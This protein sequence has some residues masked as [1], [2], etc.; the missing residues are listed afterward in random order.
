MPVVRERIDRSERLL[1]AGKRDKEATQSWQLVREELG[2]E[3][4]RYRLATATFLQGNAGE[5]NMAAIEAARNLLKQLKDVYIRQYNNAEQA[6]ERAHAAQVKRFGSDESLE[7]VRR[8]GS[9]ESL[10][11]LVRGATVKERVEVVNNR[12]YQR[13]E[14]VFQDPGNKRFFSSPF[15]IADK[16]VG[17][18]TSMSTYASNLLVIW[19]MCLL[20]FV[21]LYTDLLRRLLQFFARVSKR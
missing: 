20:L 6:R 4:T 14:P 11:D 19:S 16:P 2:P 3:A 12:I 18:G 9:N 1:K 15:F 13:Y 8:K 7:V 10:S 21:T 5:A 17:S